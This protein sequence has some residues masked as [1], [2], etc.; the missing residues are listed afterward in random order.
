MIRL[1]LGIAAM[2][3]VMLNYQPKRVSAA[4]IYADSVISFSSQTSSGDWSAAQALGA[5]NTNTYGDFPTAWSAQNPNGPPNPEYITVGY[6]T[7]FYAD[8]V[9]VWETNGNG[10]AF[11]IDLLDTSDVFHTVWT[12]TDP[13]PQGTPVGFNVTFASTAYKVKGVKVYVDPQHSLETWEEIDAVGL[14]GTLVPE[15][16]TSTLVGLGAVILVAGAIR[17]RRQRVA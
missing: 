4:L 14:S 12:G 9:T 13:S 8:G 15:P 10:F 7:P 1:G 11:Q 17:R 6:S 16:S 5:P 2:L 3:A